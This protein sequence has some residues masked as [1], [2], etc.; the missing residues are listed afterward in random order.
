MARK[1]R[2]EDIDG[3]AIINSFREDDTSIPPGARSTGV[4]LTAV[5]NENPYSPEEVSALVSTS[6][7]I[8]REDVEKKRRTA[9]PDYESI[10]ICES[11]ITARQGKQVY[12]RKEYHDRIQ[13]ILHVIGENE[14]T[15]G[16]FLDNVL[17]YHFGQF[18]SDIAESFDKH[19]KSYNL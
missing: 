3:N 10:F 4:E 16:S 18:K 11:K 14:V 2:L 15:I 5:K 13:K 17:T 6:T 12:I 8:H 9:K 7:S 19:M 1:T